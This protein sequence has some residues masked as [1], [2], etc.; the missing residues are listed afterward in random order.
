MKLAQAI[1]TDIVSATVSIDRGLKTANYYVLK[2]TDATAVLVET[3]FMTNP[4]Q[5][6]LLNSAAYQTKIA[7]AIA[8]GILNTLGITRITY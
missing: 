1:Q 7:N 3:G 2:H 5:E 4:T 8:K 6:K